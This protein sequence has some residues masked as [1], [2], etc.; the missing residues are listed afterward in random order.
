M[1]IKKKYD[2]AYIEWLQSLKAKIKSV[3]LKAVVSAN[4]EIILLYWEFGKE[5]YEKQEELGWGTSVVESLERDLKTEF[6]NVK[7]FSRRNLFY[8]KQ[9][10][11][12]YRIDFE[13][14]QQRV[15]QIPWGHNVL[16]ISK[17][18][19]KEEALFYVAE[20]INNGWSRDILDMQIKS[21]LYARQG[22]AITNFQNALLKPNSDLARQ[23]LKDPYLFDFLTLKKDA[24]EKSIEEQLT[25]H[26]TQFL[27]ELG[28]GFAFLGRQYKLAIRIFSLIYYSIIQS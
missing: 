10:Y 1:S 13:K 24:D 16:I 15:A 23:T 27:L 17:V 5:L 19:N 6:P 25:K 4:Q 18:L 9:F 8:M 26:I 28:T 2:A 11:V 20:T 21:A 22:K 7:G 3:Q 14:V 12:F